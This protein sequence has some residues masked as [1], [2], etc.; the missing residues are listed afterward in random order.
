VNYEVV[1]W[2]K[3][4]IQPSPLFRQLLFGVFLFYEQ[5]KKYDCLSFLTRKPAMD[6]ELAKNQLNTEI[7]LRG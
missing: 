2:T 4:F 3:D 7:I 1:Q 6:F 5:V